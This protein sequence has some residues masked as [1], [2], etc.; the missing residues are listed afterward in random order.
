MRTPVLALAVLSLAALSVRAQGLRERGVDSVQG[1]ATPIAAPAADP[2][3]QDFADYTQKWNKATTC[4]D[5]NLQARAEGFSKDKRNMLFAAYQA[6]YVSYCQGRTILSPQEYAKI[7]PR[8]KAGIVGVLSLDPKVLSKAEHYPLAQ[9]KFIS[10]EVMSKKIG[11]GFERL[12]KA[13]NKLFDV[14]DGLPAKKGVASYT[15]LLV[16]EREAFWAELLNHM[17]FERDCLYVSPLWE[18]LCIIGTD[19]QPSCSA[20]VRSK[21]TQDLLDRVGSRA[22]EPARRPAV[23]QGRDRS[24]PPDRSATQD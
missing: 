3:C 19:T 15:P 16:K 22:P 12:S 6:L 9:A 20:R 11:P 23:P 1:V 21:S 4:E 14:Q 7:L 10:E 2:G 8:D 24:A 18:K 17:L 5:L 13:S